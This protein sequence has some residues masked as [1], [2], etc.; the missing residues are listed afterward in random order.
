MPGA[1]PAGRTS[2]QVQET[3]QRTAR[4]LYFIHRSTYKL[5]GTGGLL[6]LFNR[7]TCPVAMEDSSSSKFRTVRGTVQASGVLGYR[8]TSHYA[9]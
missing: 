8:S 6:T 4:P 7:Y 5:T 9:L 3:L 1:D 2:A